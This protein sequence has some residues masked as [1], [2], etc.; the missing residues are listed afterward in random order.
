MPFQLLLNESI[1][2]VKNWNADRFAKLN[3]FKN[4]KTAMFTRQ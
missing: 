3:S 4:V 2:S 1:I